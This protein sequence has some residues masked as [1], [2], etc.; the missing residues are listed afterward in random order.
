M[1]YN[2]RIGKSRFPGKTVSECCDIIA[3]RAEKIN[4]ENRT[5]ADVVL[6]DMRNMEGKYRRMAYFG[7]DGKVF[8][9]INR[10]ETKC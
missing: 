8:I 7:R 9:S 5:M 1:L 3:A 6:F 4:A 2:L 10:R